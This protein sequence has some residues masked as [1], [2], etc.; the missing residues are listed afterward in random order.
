L[1][2]D[3]ASGVVPGGVAAAGAAGVIS[4]VAGV[5]GG[6]DIS[7]VVPGGGNAPGVAGVPRVGITGAATAPGAD[8]PAAVATCAPSIFLGGPELFSG[9]RDDVTGVNSDVDDIPG[10]PG[11]AITDD[12][13]VAG[14]SG[15]YLGGVHGHGLSSDRG[16][17][18][19]ISWKC[20]IS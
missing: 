14:A 2:V 8:D 12:G 18:D 11:V 1:F 3:N 10:V 9:G 5:V 15:F 19:V 13:S 7:V 4:E 6:G 16:G 17:H 20:C